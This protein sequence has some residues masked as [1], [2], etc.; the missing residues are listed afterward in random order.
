MTVDAQ[1]TLFDTPPRVDQTAGYT[2]VRSHL[3]RVDRPV[4][5]LADPTLPAYTSGSDAL[6]ARFGDHGATTIVDWLARCGYWLAPVND[7]DNVPVQA[8]RGDPP[9]VTF[10]LSETRRR[11]LAGFARAADGLTADDCN[12]VLDKATPTGSN[13]MREL[14]IAGFV[15]RTDRTRLSDRG[16]PQRVHEITD[17]GRAALHDERYDQ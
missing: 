1:P 16:Q 8:R 3:R 5:G 2:V 10:N 9:P 13:R 15:A 12:R 11:L 7:I 14:R 17:Q 4:A 6:A